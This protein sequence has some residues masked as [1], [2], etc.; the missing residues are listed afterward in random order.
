MFDKTFRFYDDF[1][2]KNYCD[3]KIKVSEKKRTLDYYSVSYSYKEKNYNPMSN[4]LSFKDH[5]D[6]E[7]IVKNEMTEKMIKYLMMDV[8]QLSELTG[9][10]TPLDYKLRI[11]VSFSYLWD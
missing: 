3:I 1:N 6:G 8:D 11:M 5:E 10:T 9:C 2:S 7:I 4:F